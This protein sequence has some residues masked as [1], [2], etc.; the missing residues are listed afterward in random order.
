MFE[1]LMTSSRRINFSVILYLP[2]RPTEP[3]ISALHATHEH[4]NRLSMVTRNKLNMEEPSAKPVERLPSWR[5]WSSEPSLSQVIAVKRHLTAKLPIELVDI[6]ISFAQYW[7]HVSNFSLTSPNIERGSDIVPLSDS[8]ASEQFRQELS[9]VTTD[10]DILL[11]RSLP[12]GF[13]SNM[14]Q[15][16][17]PSLSKHP[18]RVLYVE[19]QLR[20]A[21]PVQAMRQGVE[22][23]LES[24][25]WLELGV[26]DPSLHVPKP[27]SLWPEPERKA[28]DAALKPPRREGSEHSMFND[29]CALSHTTWLAY[30]EQ[31]IPGCLRMNLF[32]DKIPEGQSEIIPFLYSIDDDKRPICTSF[33]DPE[34]KPLILRDLDDDSRVQLNQYFDSFEKRYTMDGAKFVRNLE[35][36]DEI[37]I[38]PRVTNKDS[39]GGLVDPVV[40]IEGVRVSVFWE[41]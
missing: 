4:H 33:T 5:D 28:Q 40:V 13:P 22:V 15:P 32:L 3:H 7:P 37:G 12:L 14:S 38:W 20:W 16:W 19:V 11:H 26:L 23:L 2:S 41:F 9:E 39:V 21:M 34:W 8:E 30:Q 6:I 29:L 36:G 27:R 25:T 31:C 35:M 1:T 18:A 24:R 17:P 10:K